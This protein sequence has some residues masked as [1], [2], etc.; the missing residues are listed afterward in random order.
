MA[1]REVGWEACAE[2]A[3]CGLLNVMM[4]YLLLKPMQQ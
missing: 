2:G 1:I 3:G 4:V